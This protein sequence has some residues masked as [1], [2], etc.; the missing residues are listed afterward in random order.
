MHDKL[1]NLYEE[2]MRRTRREDYSTPAM[3]MHLAT[4]PIALE[5]ILNTD[6]RAKLATSQRHKGRRPGKPN[7]GGKM[8]QRLI[9]NDPHQGAVS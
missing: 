5:T 4:V 1:D 9:G 8:R 6:W 2:H 3:R 7:S